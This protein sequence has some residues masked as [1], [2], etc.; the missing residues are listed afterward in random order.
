MNLD[1]ESREKS[2]GLLK[3]VVL[4]SYAIPEGITFG[5]THTTRCRNS[6]RNK[7]ILHAVEKT[8]TKMMMELDFALKGGMITIGCNECGIDKDQTK[9]Y[10]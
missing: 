3:R 10:L 4:R 7:E 8:N 9:D 6:N 1:K 5:I 2:E